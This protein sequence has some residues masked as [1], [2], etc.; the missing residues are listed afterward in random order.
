MQVMAT[1]VSAQIP[2]I[3]HL[4]MYRWVLQSDFSGSEISSIS[5]TF[6]YSTMKTTTVYDKTSDAYSPE[7]GSS[8]T[9]VEDYYLSSSGI[10]TT[11]FQDYNVGKIRTGKYLVTRVTG[12]VSPSKLDVYEIVLLKDSKLV[13]KHLGEN[14]TYLHTVWNGEPQFAS[15]P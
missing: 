15:R 4:R 1:T 9:I 10:G 14:G 12:Q 8:D 3:E 11:Y 2:M 6:D 7:L 13:L 5:C